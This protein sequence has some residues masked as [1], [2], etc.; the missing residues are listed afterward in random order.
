MLALLVLTGRTTQ[1]APLLEDAFAVPPNTVG[2]LPSGWTV[3]GEGS[4][5]D[6]VA[7]ANLVYP[8]LAEGTAGSWQ[9]DGTQNQR[10]YRDFSGTGLAPGQLL[11]YSFLLK[12]DSLGKL[13]S[14]GYTSGNIMLGSSTVTAP[15]NGAVAAFSLRKDSADSTKFNIG[16][17]F[18]FRGMSN[19][20]C[21]I[22]G[23]ESWAATGGTAFSEGQTLLLVA[24]YSYAANSVSTVRF[25]V[26]PSPETFGAATAPPPMLA[27]EG[28]GS[29][30]GIP[31]QRILVGSIGNTSGAS[32][33][34]MLL[35]AF[36]VGNTWADVTP[37]GGPV[38]FALMDSLPRR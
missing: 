34:S 24:E 9:H 35:D 38:S 4:N 2:S 29:Y 21:S 17:S 33:F 32:G 13:T 30:V 18:G 10:Y 37:K 23:L 20:T 14:N 5:N 27:L 26:N 31:V 25:W 8:G 36:R 11:Y 6:F 7:S 28:K 12:V 22:I 15:G 16:V 3:G 19:N 1:G